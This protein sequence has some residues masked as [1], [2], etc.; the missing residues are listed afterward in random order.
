MQ[1][2]PFKSKIKTIPHPNGKPRV[3]QACVS[4]SPNENS[5]N[6]YLAK[7]DTQDAVYLDHVLGVYPWEF[8]V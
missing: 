3:A 4:T 5:S 1:H 2:F 7:N 8:L 6:R